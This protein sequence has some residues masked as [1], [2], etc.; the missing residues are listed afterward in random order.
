M[1]RR[2]RSH[3]PDQIQVSAPPRVASTTHVAGDLRRLSL[4]LLITLLI[5]GLVTWLAE[6][7]DLATSIGHSLYEFL[8]L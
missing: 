7:S 1:P 2:R 6:T 3:Q 8:N 5:L 4:I